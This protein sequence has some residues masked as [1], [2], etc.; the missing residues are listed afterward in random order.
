MIDNVAG[1]DGT[2]TLKGIERLQF[3]DLSVTL[4]PGLNEDPVG[5]LTVNDDSPQ[6][7]QLLTVSAADISMP[8]T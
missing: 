8:T 6:V 7:G 5:L 3:N 1:R 4:V 2:D